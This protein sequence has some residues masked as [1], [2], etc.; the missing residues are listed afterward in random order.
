[1]GVLGWRRGEG[2]FG[3][4][5]VPE[6]E[7][8]VPLEGKSKWHASECLEVL[9]EELGGEGGAHWGGLPWWEDGADLGECRLKE[10]QNSVLDCASRVWVVEDCARK[11]DQIGLVSPLSID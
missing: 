9:R 10:G 4:G 2:G 8:G 7:C 5:S 3:V 1:M 6:Y 11:S